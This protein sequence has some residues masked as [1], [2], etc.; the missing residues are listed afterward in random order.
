MRKY[1]FYGVS[2]TVENKK[3]AAAVLFNNDFVYGENPL[4]NLKDHIKLPQNKSAV[5]LDISLANAAAVLPQYIKATA[6]TINAWTNG[7]I[8]GSVI[9]NPHEESVSAE[10]EL[11]KLDDDLWCSAYSTGPGF[12]IN[13]DRITALKVQQIITSMKTLGIDP[14]NEFKK[15]IDENKIPACIYV[16]DGSG[17]KGFLFAKGENGLFQKEI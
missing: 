4:C 5:D 15:F 16:T 12:I 1:S 3:Y 7:P 9:G 10:G 6:I 8:S 14:W 2:D 13:S 17:K 11:E